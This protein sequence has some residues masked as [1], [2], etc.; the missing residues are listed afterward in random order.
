[1]NTKRAFA[2]L[3]LSALLWPGLAAAAAAVQNIDPFYLQSLKDGE[4]LYRG[5]RYREAADSLEIAAFGLNAKKDALARTRVFLALSYAYLNDSIKAESNIKS[6]LALLGSEGL[7]SYDLPDPAKADLGKLLKLYGIDKTPAAKPAA[8]SGGN[9]VPPP[10][11]KKADGPPPAKIVVP[12]AAG[13]PAEAMLKETIRR[14]PRLAESYYALAG[15]QAAAKDPA[16]AKATLGKLLENNPAEIRARLEIG[17]IE[18]GERRLKDAEK[19]LTKFLELINSVSVERI[20]VLEAKVLLALSADLRG[21]SK[22]ALA[23]IKDAPELADP[24]FRSG[25]GLTADDLERLARLLQRQ[26]K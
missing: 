8:P 16:E 15:L 19:S 5:K 24:A 10:D 20:R 2:S 11:V 22:K 1:M 21:D 14:E 26:V 4:S 23:A 9:T 3:V 12:P 6:A 7:R 25:L 13:L 17:R 18:Y